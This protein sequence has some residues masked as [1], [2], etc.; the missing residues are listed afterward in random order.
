MGKLQVMEGV[1]RE[2][3]ATGTNLMIVRFTFNKGAEVPFHTHLHEQSSY[4]LKG[5]LKLIIENNEVILTEGMAGI[6]PPNV[7]HKAV[8]L[9]DT[10]DINSFTPI[11]EDY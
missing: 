11:R 9:E 5:S 4:I 3:L 6:V 8:A 10:V 1:E 2:T 7:M